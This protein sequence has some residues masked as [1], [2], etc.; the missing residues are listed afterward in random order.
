MAVVT[1]GF[2]SVGGQDVS[3]LGCVHYISHKER[4][5]GFADLSSQF[6]ESLV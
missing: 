2:G 4:F 3:A 6:V 5:H 1:I